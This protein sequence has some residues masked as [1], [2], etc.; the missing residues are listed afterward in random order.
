MRGPEI[1][2][3][4]HK[5]SVMTQ[6]NFVLRQ[7]DRADFEVYCE[8]WNQIWRDHHLAVGELTR[9]LDTL[10]RDR[11]PTTWLISQGTA[12]VGF[13][14]LEHDFGAYHPKKW[15]LGIG[16]LPDLRGKGIGGEAYRHAMKWLGAFKPELLKVKVSDI[17]DASLGFAA[18]RGFL[19]AKRD[20]ESVLHLAKVRLGDFEQRMDDV[21]IV[22]AG[23][24]DSLDFRHEWHELFEEVR[25]DTPRTE[26]P[27]RMEFPQFNGLILDDPDCMWEGSQ[28]ALAEDRLV[29]F[30][31]LFRTG[32]EGQLFQWLTAV[33][34]EHRGKGIAKGLKLA[35][36]NWAIMNGYK[37]IRADNDVRNAP[38]L[39]IN[40]KL[41][42]QRLPGV[43][44]LVRQFDVEV[45]Q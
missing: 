28:V 10:P 29:G 23:S 37:T 45:G 5:L 25:K 15:I 36:I 39:A 13:V 27:V 31:V 33:K 43:I 35:G 12:D 8:L 42:F 7:I 21:E 41:G 6:A 30:S 17:D 1:Y 22:P 9:E 44:T 32:V 20:F 19:E 18:R 38:M 3:E 34:R 40:D 11:H 4:L 14:K 16:V 26:P 2:P 24:R